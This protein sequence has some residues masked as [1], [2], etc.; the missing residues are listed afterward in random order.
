MN[1]FWGEE[2]KNAE[3]IYRAYKKF[4]ELDKLSAKKGEAGNELDHFWSAKLL[5]DFDAALTGLSSVF[6]CLFIFVCLFLIPKICLF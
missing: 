3:T 5:E 6:V 4:V 2:K 1:G